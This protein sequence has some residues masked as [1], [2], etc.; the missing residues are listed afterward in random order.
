MFFAAVCHQPM[1]Y[2][3]HL[4]DRLTVAV[5]H[6]CFADVVEFSNGKA[7]IFDELLFAVVL[8]TA[9]TIVSTFYY[10]SI[11]TNPLK[12]KAGNTNG[13]NRESTEPVSWTTENLC[14]LN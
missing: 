13:L 12:E 14:N 6:F 5:W 3:L 4:R 7:G 2:N 9:S 10:S 1:S 11:L 8:Y